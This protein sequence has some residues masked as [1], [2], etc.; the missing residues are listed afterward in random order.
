MLSLWIRW[1]L[2]WVYGGQPRE[3]VLSRQPS[4]VIAERGSIRMT[5]YRPTGRK[6]V[7]RDNDV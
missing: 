3:P 7:Y 5:I 2:H 4:G 1:Y 6:E